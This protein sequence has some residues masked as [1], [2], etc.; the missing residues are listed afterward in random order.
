[1][2]I[3]YRGTV[4]ALPIARCASS[5]D[6]SEAM[7]EIPLVCSAPARFGLSTV[8]CGSDLSPE[9]SPVT[10]SAGFSVTPLAVAHAV[11]WL[12]SLLISA[13]EAYWIA[14]L[15][16]VWHCH[17]TTAKFWMHPR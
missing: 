14:P 10:N 2:F 9:C 11:F 16:L 15:A 5:R 3:G 17:G 4:R 13:A 1:M 8:I 6:A 7:K 12:I